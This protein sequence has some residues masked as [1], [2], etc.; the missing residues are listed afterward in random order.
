[1]TSYPPHSILWTPL[2]PISYLFPVVGHVGISNWRGDKLVDFS[3][4]SADIVSVF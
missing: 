4:R 2:G 3:G 1:M